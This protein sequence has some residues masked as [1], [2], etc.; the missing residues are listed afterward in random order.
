MTEPRFNELQAAR[1]SPTSTQA[2]W[3]E[4]IVVSCEWEEAG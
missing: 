2:D 1:P 4:G 3:G